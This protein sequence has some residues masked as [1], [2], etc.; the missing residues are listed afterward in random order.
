MHVLVT[1][2]TGF[3]GGNL[4]RRLIDRGDRVAVFRRP[5]SSLRA[6]GPL[7]DRVEHRIGRI[8][9]A[10]AVRRAVAGCEVVFHVAGD[11]SFWGPDR[12]RQYATNV[13]GTRNVVRA[14]LDAKVRRLVHTSSVAAVGVPAGRSPAD[15]T[16]P[17][18]LASRS[19]Y[20]FRTKR[21]AEEEVAAGVA[22][23]LDAVMANPS[24][25]LGPGW[26]NMHGRDLVQL[27]ARRQIPAYPP[28]GMNVVDVEDIVEGHLLALEKGRKGERYILGSENLGHGEI[29][30]QIAEIVGVP[31]PRIRFPGFISWLAT[32]PMEAWAHFVTHR[33][34]LMTV[35]YARLAGLPLY[36]RH[37]KAAR[38]LGYRPRPFKE[39]VERS[40]RW[41]KSEGLL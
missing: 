12:P 8:D 37:D 36:Y 6:L 9:D 23:G 28:G 15:E 25:I 1:G 31:P 17:F 19:V 10:E 16:Q 2:A 41:L 24:V 29:M 27:I 32:W 34:P 38:E 18:T 30:R 26:G 22:A 13:I 7:A 33:T 35:D 5:T 3:V 39:V 14:C 11:V 4:V 21:M 40:W 20:Y